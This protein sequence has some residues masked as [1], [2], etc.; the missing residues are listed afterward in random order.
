MIIT[1]TKCKKSSETKV[2]NWRKALSLPQFVK[3]TWNSNL[4]ALAEEIVGLQI[5]ENIQNSGQKVGLSSQNTAKFDSLD[6]V[7]LP[8]IFSHGIYLNS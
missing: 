4:R 5:L 1:I 8:A 3:F 6:M 2:S 7:H